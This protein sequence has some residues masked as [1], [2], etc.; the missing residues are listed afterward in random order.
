MNK[1][2]HSVFSVYEVYLKKDEHGGYSVS[3]PMLPECRATGKD[4]AEALKNMKDAIIECLKHH[5]PINE[6]EGNRRF[7]IV[8]TPK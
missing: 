8:E 2:S 1:K 7:V 5:S 4:E 3:S 6:P